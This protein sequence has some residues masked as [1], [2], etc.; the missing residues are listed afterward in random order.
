MARVAF[1]FKMN[2]SF[3]RPAP[4]WPMSPPH[5][6]AFTLIE[7]LVVIAIIAIL[8]G[9][10]LPAL[11]KAKSK[12]QQARCISN[13]KQVS[14]GTTMYATDYNDTFHNLGGAVPNHGQ[15][16]RTPATTDLLPASDDFAYWG[17]AYIKY[18]GGSKRVF[19]CPGAKV[20]DQWRED[21]LRYPADFWLDSS[22]GIN[23]YITQP[24]VPGNPT[25]R[26]PGPRKLTDYQSPQTMIF[27]Q[28]AAEQR[29]DGAD[30]ML[31]LF[32]GSTEILTQWR[33]GSL[34]TLYPGVNFLWEWYRHNKRCDTLWVPGNVSSIRYNDARR[35]V[36][37]RW[38]TGVAP[39]EQP[40][41]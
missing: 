2:T 24:P 22:Y 26:L 41:F 31:G 39:I 6:R 34:P 27:A 7:L 29:M 19:R 32:P 36:D 25:S 40:S 11:A 30:D 17:V 5:A 37:F 8:A 12:G 18:F 16:T 13:L 15:W 21:G 9:M 14:I 38:Y 1:H 33:Y 35:G 4:A 10:I 3:K 28:D 20:V 23:A